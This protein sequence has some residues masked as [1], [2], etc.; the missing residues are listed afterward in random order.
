MCTTGYEAGSA[1]SFTPAGAPAPHPKRQL[2]AGL[3][4][5]LRAVMITKMAKPEEVRPE[6][7]GLRVGLLPVSLLLGLCMDR[8]SAAWPFSF[9][10]TKLRKRR[11]FYRPQVNVVEDEGWTPVTGPC[12]SQSF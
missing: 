1:F 11:I 6:C 3:L 4:A 7:V 9:S 10:F 8:M 2:Y 12:P 5:K